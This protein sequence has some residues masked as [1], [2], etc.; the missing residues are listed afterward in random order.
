MQCSVINW[1]FVYNIRNFYGFDSGGSAGDIGRCLLG[2]KLDLSP[3]QTSTTRR[4]TCGATPETYV[5]HILAAHCV[6]PDTEF[7]CCDV[8]PRV[9]RMYADLVAANVSLVWKQHAVP[10]V[11]PHVASLIARYAAR[12]RLNQWAHSARAQ[13]PRI[14]FLFERPPTVCG[15]IIFLN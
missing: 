12:G 2:E 8:M 6:Q 14:F 7:R 10:H 1:I 3:L 4:A 9:L 15:E 13:G 5:G 11:A